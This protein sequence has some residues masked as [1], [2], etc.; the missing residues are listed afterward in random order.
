MSPDGVDILPT[1]YMPAATPMGFEQ[2]GIPRG[3]KRPL[4][5][6]AHVRP[7]SASRA[8]SAPKR[9]RSDQFKVL[10]PGV[11]DGKI[12][13]HSDSAAESVPEQGCGQSNMS[14]PLVLDTSVNS[15]SAVSSGSNTPS[16]PNDGVKKVHFAES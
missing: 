1:Q 5:D 16:T 11:V 9:S 13:A 4:S 12:I 10:Q 6:Y 3:V 8:P 15:A 2:C 14:E 7:I